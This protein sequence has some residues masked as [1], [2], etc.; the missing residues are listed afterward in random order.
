MQYR[1]CLRLFFL[2]SLLSPLILAAQQKDWQLPKHLLSASFGRAEQRQTDKND[3]KGLNCGGLAYTFHFARHWWAGAEWQ[4]GFNTFQWQPQQLG[5]GKSTTDFV[6]ELPVFYRSNA[7]YDGLLFE[8][9]IH[10]VPIAKLPPNGFYEYRNFSLLTGYTLSTPSNIL[11]FGIG[12]SR[13]S[14]Q[15]RDIIRTYPNGYPIGP[16]LLEYKNWESAFN[17]VL[18]Y[19][20]FLI[21]K[22]AAGIRLTTIL[23]VE[24]SHAQHYSAMLSLGY[25]LAK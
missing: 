8:P 16:Y 5:I 24:T 3:M 9:V 20:F 2:A 7:I 14:V 1:F 17:A 10:S 15:I 23:G 12:F 4:A 22:L 19:D 21:P 18:H 13:N 6:T 11:R 25:A